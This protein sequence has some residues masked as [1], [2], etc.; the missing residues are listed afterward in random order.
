MDIYGG[1]LIA[2]RIGAEGVDEVEKMMRNA[3]LLLG[4]RLGGSD[5]HNEVDLHRITAHDLAAESFGN[6]DRKLGLARRGVTDY[7]NYLRLHFL[8][9]GIFAATVKSSG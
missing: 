5:I 3:R 4:G 6:S 2:K 1:S 7:G 9:I 8:P